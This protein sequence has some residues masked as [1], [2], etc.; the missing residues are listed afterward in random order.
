MA[1]SLNFPNAQ[2]RLAGDCARR[3]V[4]MRMGSFLVYYLFLS[5]LHEHS[6]CALLAP[7]FNLRFLAKE[8][9]PI[10]VSKIGNHTGKEIKEYTT[11]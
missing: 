6:Y 2:Q 11:A 8:V 1:C 9:L 3:P 4:K 10:R 5:F 7:I